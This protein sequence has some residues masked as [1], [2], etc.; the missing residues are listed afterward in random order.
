MAQVF[1]RVLRHDVCLLLLVLIDVTVV[2]AHFPKQ[3]LCGQQF[4]EV[5]GSRSLHAD[6]VDFR[7]VHTLPDCFVALRC[8]HNPVN[9][10]LTMMIPAGERQSQAVGRKVDT[11][12][13][14][15]HLFRLQMRIGAIALQFVVHLRERGHP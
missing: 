8:V 1:Q 15:L 3:M 2:D 6:A 10:V 14:G 4:Q 12:F 7:V 9:H 11:C 5:Q 13:Q